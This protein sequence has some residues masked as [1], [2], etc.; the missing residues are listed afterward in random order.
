MNEKDAQVLI[1]Y[2]SREIEKATAAKEKLTAGD[3]NKPI[4]DVVEIAKVVG[5]IDGLK[6]AITLIEKAVG[7]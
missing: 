3:D 2:L 6:W 4:D 1:K 5:Y 7:E